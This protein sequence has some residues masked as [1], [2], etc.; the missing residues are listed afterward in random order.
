MILSSAVRAY[1]CAEPT[2]MRK[3]MDTLSQL[4]QPVGQVFVFLSRHIKEVLL[5]KLPSLC[6][7]ASAKRASTEQH[8]SAWSISVTKMTKSSLTI[9][10]CRLTFDA[11]TGCVWCGRNSSSATGLRF[12]TAIITSHQ[13]ILGITRPSASLSS[14]LCSIQ[15]HCVHLSGRSSGRR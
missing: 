9:F 15:K 10:D 4:V 12:P 5:A 8:S 7:L 6:H 11:H 14:M 2:D 13:T 1:V 3:S